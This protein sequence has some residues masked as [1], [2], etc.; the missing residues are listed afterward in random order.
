VEVTL[1]VA[2]DVPHVF[3]AFAAVLD[4]GDEALAS[5]GR[6]LASHLRSRWRSTEPLTLDDLKSDRLVALRASDG[7][8]ADQ[9]SLHKAIVFELESEDEMFVLS[10]GW[11]FRVNR[12]FKERPL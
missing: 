2:Q 11:W 10:G 5:M 6:F 7:G 4:E 12:D 1:E 9:W 3:Q 8:L